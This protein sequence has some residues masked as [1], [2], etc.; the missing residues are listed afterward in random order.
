ME[1]I[2]YSLAEDRIPRAWYNIVPDLPKPLA[3]VLQSRQCARR[4][5][6]RPG[7]TLVPCSV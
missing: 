2:K 1:S 5:A 4:I 7:L 3:P 6:R